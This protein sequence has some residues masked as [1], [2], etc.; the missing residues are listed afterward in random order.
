MNVIKVILIVGGAFL[1]AMLMFFG[2][3]IVDS[4][5]ICKAMNLTGCLK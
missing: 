3:A 5:D 1:F 4:H 2:Y